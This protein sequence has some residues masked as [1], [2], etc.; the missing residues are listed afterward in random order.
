[1]RRQETPLPPEHGAPR[2]EN[3]GGR[4]AARLLTVGTERRAVAAAGL[5]F[6][7]RQPAQPELLQ[8]LQQKSRITHAGVMLVHAAHPALIDKSRYRMAV[9]GIDDG[10]ALPEAALQHFRFTKRAQQGAGSGIRH[11]AA[12]FLMQ[13][14]KACQRRR[15]HGI[16]PGIRI[17]GSGQQIAPGL[18]APLAVAVGVTAVV[19][20]PGQNQMGLGQT[21]KAQQSR[22]EFRRIVGQKNRDAAGG[23]VRAQLH[24]HVAHHSLIVV[25]GSGGVRRGR[26]RQA[27]GQMFTQGLTEAAAHIAAVQP[28]AAPQQGQLTDTLGHHAR[29]GR[30]NKTGP[31]FVLQARTGQQGVLRA[32]AYIQTEHRPDIAQK[33]VYRIMHGPVPR[34]SLDTRKRA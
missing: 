30:Q 20:R 34:S 32:A 18:H 16:Y 15:R 31:V 23:T 3:V 10:N 5:H 33:M 13:G 12:R 28:E 4:I 17:G 2:S 25:D 8:I 9:A 14:P 11:R 27:R 21:G 19:L 29:G 22:P 1:M 24:A 6:F 7:R 26:R